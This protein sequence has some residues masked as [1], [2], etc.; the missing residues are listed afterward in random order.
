MPSPLFPVYRFFF[1]VAKLIANFGVKLY[2][3]IVAGWSVTMCI[4]AQNV[5]PCYKHGVSNPKL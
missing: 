3:S 2:V 5:K 1:A 4:L